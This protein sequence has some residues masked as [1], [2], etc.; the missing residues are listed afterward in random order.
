MSAAAPA[1]APIAPKNRLRL[2]S[3]L[4]EALDVLDEDWV[5]TA[6]AK[7]LPERTVLGRHLLANMRAPRTMIP[8]DVSCTTPRAMKFIMSMLST[9]L[10]RTMPP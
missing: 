3:G 10:L 4:L 9:L 6:R 5:R 2:S 1:L 8:S 7:G